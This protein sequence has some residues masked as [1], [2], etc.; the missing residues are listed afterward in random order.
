MTRLAELPF[1]LTEIRC[2]A[3]RIALLVALQIR[4]AFFDG[5]AAQATAIVHRAKMRLMDEI[6][7]A[8][9]FARD[10][11][12]REIDD[13]SIALDVVNAVALCA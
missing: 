8:A 10:R 13:P 7:E 11:S 5:V 2:K 1:H 12:L 6:R 3:S 4:A 9:L